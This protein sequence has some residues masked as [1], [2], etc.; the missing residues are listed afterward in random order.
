MVEELKVEEESTK[1]ITPGSYT[2]GGVDYTITKTLVTK[3]GEDVGSVDSNGKITM[4][5]SEDVTY[6]ISVVKD[7]TLTLLEKSGAT[8]K[9]YKG[10]FLFTGKTNTTL[11][12]TA[13]DS[14]TIQFTQNAEISV[15]PDGTYEIDG[16]DYTISGSAVTKVSDGSG[17]GS[18]GSDGIVT[19]NKS[20]SETIKIT[21]FDD[22]SV[23]LLKTT[24]SDGETTKKFYKGAFEDNIATLKKDG[25]DST[26]TVVIKKKAQS[27]GSGEGEG[28]SGSGG[29]TGGTG[30]GD[31]SSAE[32]ADIILADGTIIPGTTATLTDEQKAN[33]IGIV[34]S[35]FQ[36]PGETEQTADGTGNRPEGHEE[37][38]HGLPEEDH[39]AVQQAVRGYAG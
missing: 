21:V 19:V 7:G 25:T 4:S 10:K 13:D 26:D 37:G 31:G 14:D 34:I 1:F 9:T 28:E 8:A 6:D 36:I 20:D 18:V 23:E 15:I 39:G 27:S 5:V 30:T 2:I 33:A 17:A 29:T 3:N 12:N 32:C 38:N 11:K 35:Q 24:T 22:L 16:T